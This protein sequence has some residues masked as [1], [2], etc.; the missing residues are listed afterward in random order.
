VVFLIGTKTKVLCHKNII[1]TDGLNNAQREQLIAE[2]KEG[3]F[4]HISLNL[5]TNYGM[6]LFYGQ[7]EILAY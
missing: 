1:G 3:T 2:N 5:S 6:L 7:K 4:R